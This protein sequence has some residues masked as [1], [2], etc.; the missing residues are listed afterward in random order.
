VRELSGADERKLATRVRE[1]SGAKEEKRR[2]QVYRSRNTMRNYGKVRGTMYLGK[3]IKGHSTHQG[4][5]RSSG[6]SGTF[7]PTYS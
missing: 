3:T 7:M 4:S 2:K 1:L 5:E 6:E